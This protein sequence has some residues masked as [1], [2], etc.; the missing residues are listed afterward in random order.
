M[1]PEPSQ[2]RRAVLLCCA[3]RGVTRIGADFRRIVQE[4]QRR[5]GA[6]QHVG[7]SRPPVAGSASRL[8]PEEI[9]A[10]RGCGAIE[11]VSGRL[12]PF[13]TQLVVQQG[14]Q[15]RRD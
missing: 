7:E 8:A 15:L 9:L 14:G 12:W 3:P 11:A 10:T 5:T 13:Q 4:G 2:R 6:A 1:L